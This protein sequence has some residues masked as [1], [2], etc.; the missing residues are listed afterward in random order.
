MNNLFVVMLACGGSALL[1]L[2]VIAV[3]NASAGCATP[4]PPGAGGP[5]RPSLRVPAAASSGRRSGWPRWF[6]KEV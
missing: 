6:P 5:S 2:F 3:I 1:V 4:S